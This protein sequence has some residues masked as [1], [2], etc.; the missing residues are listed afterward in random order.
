MGTQL[1]LPK[2]GTEP[3]PQFSAYVYIV[4]KQLDGSR[5]HLKGL[6]CFV[7]VL[8]LGCVI[9]VK[10]AMRVLTEKQFGFVQG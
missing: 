4:A 5:W 8:L 1:S 2:K 7:C 3:P 9:G 10:T 6:A